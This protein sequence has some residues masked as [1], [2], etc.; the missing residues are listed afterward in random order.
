MVWQK[1]TGRKK[2]AGSTVLVSVIIP[3]FNAAAHLRGALES[4]AAQQH[5]LFEVLCV[6]DGSTDGSQD[7]V[8]EFA[9]PDPRF[10][11]LE[12]GKLG[13]G[14]ARNFGFAQAQGEFTVFLDAD[15]VFHPELLS[16]TTAELVRS[17]ADI[18]VYGGAAFPGAESG[19]LPA[20]GAVSEPK[21]SYLAAGALPEKLPFRPRDVAERIF[22]LATPAPWLRLYRTEFLRGRGLEFQQVARSND[23]AFTMTSMAVAA[24]ISALPR[25]LVHYRTG[26]GSNLQA[27]LHASPL[28]FVEALRGLRDNLE[29][30]GVLGDF[31]PAFQN[32]CVNTVVHNLRKTTTVAAYVEV[33]N[34]ARDTLLAE[35]GLD[36]MTEDDFFRRED[37]LEISQVKT[38]PAEQSLLE[39]RTQRRELWRLRGDLK[40]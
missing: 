24:K 18:C 5:E 23:L 39:S 37:F 16:L 19:S 2:S 13:A 17:G 40:K 29:H 36:T 20:G 26:H 31:R 34:F 25:P 12:P 11:L 21:M 35:F 38:I 22:E 4:L 6:D 7:I 8:R 33:Y 10:R 14:G 27:N 30:H 9:G 1:L 32:L 3:V 15:D 28:D